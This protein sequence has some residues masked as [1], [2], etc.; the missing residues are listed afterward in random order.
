M[1]TPFRQKSI[2]TSFTSH[3]LGFQNYNN[4]ARALLSVQEILAIPDASLLSRHEINEILVRIYNRFDGEFDV[5]MN[6]E[7]G[8]HPRDNA[9]FFLNDVFLFLMPKIKFDSLKESVLA[10]IYNVH[11][12]RTGRSI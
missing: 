9:C 2:A 6:Y 5:A 12:L 4:D 3:H 10:S 1:I 7:Q 11:V 8:R